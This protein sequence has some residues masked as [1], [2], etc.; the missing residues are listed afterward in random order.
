MKDLTTTKKNNFYAVRARQ[1]PL[2]GR[3]VRGNV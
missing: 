3:K 2:P 1:T